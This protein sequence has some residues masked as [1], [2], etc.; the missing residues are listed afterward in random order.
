MKGKTH[1]NS[2]H[3]AISREM[4]WQIWHGVVLAR[5]YSDVSKLKGGGA[6]KLTRVGHELKGAAEFTI[7]RS[8]ASTH[9]EYVG[10]KRGEAL[11]VG[12]P[13]RR[14]YDA[15]A[16]FILVLMKGKKEGRSLR[17]KYSFRNIS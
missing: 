17:F 7:T 1:K 8:R 16:S 2:Y 15:I 4:M 9:M 6:I 5:R 14:F 13:G 12:I 10:R 11:D 3:C